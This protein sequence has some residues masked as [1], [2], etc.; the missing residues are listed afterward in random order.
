VTEVKI[1]VGTR[2]KASIICPQCGKHKEIDATRHQRKGQEHKINFTCDCGFSFDV[3]FNF[4]EHYR[5]DTHLYGHCDIAGY[6]DPIEITVENLSTKGIG[7]TTRTP[8][9]VSEGDEIEVEFVLKDKKRSLIRKRV[10][11]RRIIN[12]YIAAEFRDMK[13]WDKDLGFYMRS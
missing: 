7:F 11:V 4:R 3:S 1:Q 5:K 12:N 10:T 13:A 9:K 8:V 2:D 6:R